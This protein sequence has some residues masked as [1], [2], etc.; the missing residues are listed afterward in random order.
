MKYE[1][2]LSTGLP[3]VIPCGVPSKPTNQP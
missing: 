3:S 1:G 2:R